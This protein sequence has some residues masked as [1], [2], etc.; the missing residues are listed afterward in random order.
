M[1]TAVQRHASCSCVVHD[2][3]PSVR[4]AESEA[5]STWPSCLDALGVC[6]GKP[7]P[8]G[9]SHGSAQQSVR[10]SLSISQYQPRTVHHTSVQATDQIPLRINAVPT[11]AWLCVRRILRKHEQTRCNGHDMITEVSR[12]LPTQKQSRLNYRQEIDAFRINT[13]A[14][15]LAAASAESGKALETLEASILL[16]IHSRTNRGQMSSRVSDALFSREAP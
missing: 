10:R 2:I 6:C 5:R 14:A 15:L 8:R 9:R 12:P 16:T 13:A 11:F 4:L 3:G 1:P 7:P